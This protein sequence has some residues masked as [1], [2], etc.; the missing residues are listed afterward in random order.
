MGELNAEAILVGKGIDRVLDV[1][2]CLRRGDVGLR[3]EET[4]R[5]GFNRYWRFGYLVV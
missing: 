3:F 5:R 4:R 2:G 1:G